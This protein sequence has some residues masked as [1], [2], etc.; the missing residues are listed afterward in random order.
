MTNL[1]VFLTHLDFYTVLLPSFT[2]V[3]VDRAYLAED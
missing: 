1:L 3:R 2:P